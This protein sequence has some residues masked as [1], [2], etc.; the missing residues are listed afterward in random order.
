MSPQL[1]FVDIESL[2]H[3]SLLHSVTASPWGVSGR[4]G[5]SDDDDDWDVFPTSHYSAHDQ[6][7]PLFNI[8]CRW[9]GF[10]PSGCG[11]VDVPV[12]QV[13]WSHATI[14][15]EV[16]DAKILNLAT[17]M[18]NPTMHF[19]SAFLRYHPILLSLLDFRLTSSPSPSVNIDTVHH[20]LFDF[21]LEFLREFK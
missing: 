7:P 1:N 6:L 14:H 10:V 12:V 5:S 16:G 13:S 18:S 9:V 21:S 15:D 2:V 11:G 4:F 20:E 8:L 17:F 3:Q 19:Y